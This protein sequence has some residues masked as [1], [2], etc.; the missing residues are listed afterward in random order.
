MYALNIQFLI[1]TARKFPKSL[2]FQYPKNCSSSLKT[3]QVK[4]QPEER[5]FHRSFACDSLDGV[6]DGKSSFAGDRQADSSSVPFGG[7]T[8]YLHQIPI[9]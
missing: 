5:A 9:N 7:K 4:N 1:K 3:I 2:N 6:D 8:T